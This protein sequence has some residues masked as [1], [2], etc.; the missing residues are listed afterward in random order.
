MEKQFSAQDQ[1]ARFKETG[2]IISSEGSTAFYGF[3]D[4]F[5]KDSSLEKKG[6]ALMR[7]AIKFLDNHPEVDRTKVYIWFK[8]NCPMVG[9]LYDDFRIADLETGKIVFT[10]TPKCSHSGLAE[11]WG[12]ENSF[13]GPIKTAATFKE[14][15]V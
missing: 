3:C 15:L 1:I 8:N 11:V 4:W 6:P 7:K 2:E 12:M 14:L 10:V 13:S 5:C 9:P